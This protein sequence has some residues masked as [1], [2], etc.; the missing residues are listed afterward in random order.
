[1]KPQTTLVATLGGQ[2]QIITFTLDLLRARGARINQVVVV[3]LASEPRYHQAF[4]KLSGEF[5]GDQYQGE[6]MHLRSI[7]VRLRNATLADA[8][9]PEEVDAVWRTFHDLFVQ[10][11]GQEQCLHLS[12]TGGRR[13]L[14]LLAFSVAMLQFGT[15]DRVWH[16]YTPSEIVAQAYEGKRMHVSAEAGLRL[17]EVPLVPWGAYLP[18]MRPLLSRSPQEVRVA[19]QGWLDEADRARCQQTWEKLTH[20]QKDV[21]RTLAGGKTRQETAEK[22]SLSISTIDDH[23][24][25][26]LNHCRLI[27]D[28]EVRLDVHFLRKHFGP[29]LAALGEV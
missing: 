11:K 18:G 5:T 29:Y 15:A 24:T 6:R 9:T 23:K 10:L 1:M 22:L 7:P 16:L 19:H 21:L 13:I 27:W 12:L 2:P 26:I 3:Y 20:R 28:T 25:K 8:H 17:I 14:S 4:R